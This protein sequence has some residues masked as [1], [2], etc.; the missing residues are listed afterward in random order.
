MK[1]YQCIVVGAAQGTLTVAI[2]DRSDREVIDALRKQTGRTVFPVVIP[3]ARMR[4]L[5]QR[6]ERDQRRM[7]TLWHLY[8]PKRFQVHGMLQYILL[9]KK[10]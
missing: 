1:R 5:L 2:S 4:L 6:I 10:K 9:Y 7:G 3:E 8:Y